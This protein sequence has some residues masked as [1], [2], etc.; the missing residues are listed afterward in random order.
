MLR[1]K[2]VASLAAAAALLAA[3]PDAEACGDKLLSMSRGIRLQQ[4]YK[5]RHPARMLM[6]VGEIREDHDVLLELGIL[7]MSLRQ[8]GHQIDVAESTDEL[9]SALPKEDYDFVL[10]AHR[11]ITGVAVAIAGQPSRA[12]LLPVLFE[13][14]AQELADAQEQFVLVL[15]TP[16]SSTDHLEAIDRVVAGARLASRH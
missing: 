8:A 7:Y 5:A 1:T 4:A 3:Q 13:P 2:A 16:A 15:K 14:G 12:A 11:E 10:A 9:R 6:Y